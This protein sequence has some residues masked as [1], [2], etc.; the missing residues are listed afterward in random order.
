MSVDDVDEQG[1]YPLG[2]DRSAL[3]GV[4]RSVAV[5]KKLRVACHRGP[6]VR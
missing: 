1:A 5:L 2:P 6:R 3:L 4:T